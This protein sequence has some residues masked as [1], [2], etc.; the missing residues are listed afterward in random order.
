MVDSV[1]PSLSRLSR[2]CGILNISGDI[3]FLLLY[4]NNITVLSSWRRSRT[5]MSE[6]GESGT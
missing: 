5:G 6:S 4:I 1:M 3:F 2:Q